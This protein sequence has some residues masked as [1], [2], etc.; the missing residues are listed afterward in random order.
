MEG[1]FFFPP[2]RKKMSTIR[3]KSAGN[4]YNGMREFFLSTCGGKISWEEFFFVLG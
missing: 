4:F 1:R 2:S 3:E